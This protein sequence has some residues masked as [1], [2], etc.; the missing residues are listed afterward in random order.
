MIVLHVMPRLV[1]FGPQT[2]E[3]HAPQNSLKNDTRE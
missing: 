1:I 2:P 3:I